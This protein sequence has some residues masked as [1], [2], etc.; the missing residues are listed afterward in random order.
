MDKWIWLD[1]DGTIADLYGVQGWLEDIRAYKTRPYEVAQCLYNIY[2]LWE[3]LASV[4]DKGYKVGI[5]SW[6]SKI[7]TADFD[8]A[9][10]K[11]KNEWLYMNCLDVVID[12]VII[13]AHG[14]SK[15]DTCRPYGYGILVDDEE[16]NR[17]TWDLGSTIDANEDIIK[18]LRALI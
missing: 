10:T 3:A 16:K 9:V 18:R 12:K 5:I 11:A 15:A 4:H 1:M 14:I 7:S 2:E 17:A 8:R 6:G 13:T